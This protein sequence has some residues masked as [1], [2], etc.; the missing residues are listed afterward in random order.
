MSQ[1]QIEPLKDQLHKFDWLYSP[2]SFQVMNQHLNSPRLEDH[3]ERVPVL[4][5]LVHSTV[6]NSVVKMEGQV[7][8]V[9]RF[10]IFYPLE[11]A[12]LLLRVE[13]IEPFSIT[14]PNS[15]LYASIRVAVLVSYGNL[16]GNRH[17]A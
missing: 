11:N 2:Q 9:E 6:F 4:V 17:G 1:F 10:T 13:D 16:F 14:D 7:E 15:K 8:R 5:D 12:L 3:P